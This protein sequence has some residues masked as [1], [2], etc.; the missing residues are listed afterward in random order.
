[1]L[2]Q[3]VAE[4]AQRAPLRID[5]PEMFHA[6]ALVFAEFFDEVSSKLVRRYS[7]IEIADF[8]LIS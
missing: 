6:P 8:V 7:S 5:H 4:D 3:S 2:E 1:V